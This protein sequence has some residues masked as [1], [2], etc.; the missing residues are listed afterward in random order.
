MEKWHKK[1]Y[2]YVK[3]SMKQLPKQIVFVLV[4]VAFCH[5]A[6]G[7][8]ENVS[9]NAIGLTQLQGLNINLNGAGIR[10]GH[11]EATFDTN[12]DWE[13]NPGSVLQPT[14]HFTYY[15]NSG[16]SSMY[17]NSLGGDSGHA[18]E[19][20]QIFYAPQVGIA[21]NVAH[22]DN[23]QAVYYFDDIIE[24]AITLPGG[25][26][27]AVVNQS[28]TFNALDANTQE[29]VDSDY[30]DYST[31]FKTLFI[32]AVYNGGQVCAPGTSYDCIGVGAYG[33]SS[34]V[35]PTIDNGRC[36]PDIIAPQ[37]ETSFS[38][39]QV[40][41][42]AAILMQ[43]GLRGDGGTATNS[44]AN[45]ITVKALLLNGAVKPADWANIPPSPL[46]YRYGAGVLNVFNSYEQLAGG[47]HAYNFTTNIP[48]G[49][50][51]PPVVTTASI[52]ALS[53]WDFNT[54]TSS[55]SKD[56]VNHYFFNA[57]NSG[58]AFT[59]T[60]TLVWNRDENESAI[61]NLALF[62]Y[63]AANSNLVASSTS[64]V[65]NVQ[66]VFVPQLPQGRYDL[67]VWKAGGSGIVSNSEPYAVAWAIASQSLTI[68]QSGTNVGLSWP[69]YP[70]GFAV[71]A[72]S[73]LSAPV[74]WSTNNIPLPVF[75]NGQDVLWLNAAA[76]PQFFRLQTPNF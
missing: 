61:N 24:R 25:V 72:A 10:V 39:P 37:G 13:V 45:M 26:T 44:A 23:P 47:K 70:A 32:S 9:T 30:D 38:T 12:G 69:A 66:H 59:L 16:S 52:P 41:G 57:T 33:G 67:Q 15:T 28:F 62:L 17:P 40:A 56:G 60:A 36:K 74:A 29:T 42:S 3:S 2:F 73:S 54:N 46:D 64:V 65:D 35:G 48:M 14:N 8:S 22:V 75:T 27:D 53:G 4:Y 19:V 58:A 50:A 49:T 1:W 51:H 55:S 6:L 11:A 5:L 71:A 43:A 31:K 76:K 7:A 20:G 21:T 18:D 63:N 68:T 34:S